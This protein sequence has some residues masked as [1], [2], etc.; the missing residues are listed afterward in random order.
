MFGAL[1]ALNNG[2]LLDPLHDSIQLSMRRFKPPEQTVIFRNKIVKRCCKQLS[3][4]LVLAS[5]RDLA[6]LRTRSSIVLQHTQSLACATVV[7]DGADERRKRIIFERRAR[8][9]QQ[10]RYM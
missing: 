4:R 6:E 9:S 7:H 5:R 10:L 1:E 3:R 8:H 2:S